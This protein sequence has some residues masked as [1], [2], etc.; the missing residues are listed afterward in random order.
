MLL[1]I[2]LSPD[3]YGVLLTTAPL[4]STASHRFWL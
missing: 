2:F 3:L 4:H 1:F